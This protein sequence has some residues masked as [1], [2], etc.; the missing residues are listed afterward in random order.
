MGEHEY[1][2]VTTRGGGR[3]QN[4]GTYRWMEGKETINDRNMNRRKTVVQRSST[5][6]GIHSSTKSAGVIGVGETS[7]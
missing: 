2:S 3:D 5:F 7:N 6:V 1:H 4:K